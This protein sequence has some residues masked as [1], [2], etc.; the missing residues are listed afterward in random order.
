MF[1]DVEVMFPEGVPPEHITLKICPHP[2]DITFKIVSDPKDITFFFVCDP[3]AITF[4][5]CPT[6][7]R[8]GGALV[9]DKIE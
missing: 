3:K 1:R 6:L 7:G 9:P 5:S 2:Q 4:F 8:S